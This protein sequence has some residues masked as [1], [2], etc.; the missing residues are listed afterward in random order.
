MVKIRASRSSMTDWC[1][2]KCMEIRSSYLPDRR[3][4][5][6][7][8]PPGNRR[9]RSHPL[10]STMIVRSEPALAATQPT[11]D[12]AA[13]AGQWAS[14]LL[15]LLLL[16]LVLIVTL[17]LVALI[18]RRST[19]G[20]RRHREADIPDAWEEAGRRARPPTQDASDTS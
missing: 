16:G 8:Q 6:S 3:T 19:D 13:A 9:L 15:V 2:S 17:V 11:P 10:A 20:N 5:N 18:R 12:Q 1:V 7:R 14:L 4:A